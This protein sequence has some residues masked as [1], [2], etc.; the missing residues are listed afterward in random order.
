MQSLL[1]AKRCDLKIYKEFL[2]DQKKQLDRIEDSQAPEWA[3]LTRSIE[4]YEWV[5]LESE[6]QIQELETFGEIRE[7]HWM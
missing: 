4:Y 7:V 2:N 1:E 3:S 5:V 6:S